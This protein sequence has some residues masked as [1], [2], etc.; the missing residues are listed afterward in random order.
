MKNKYEINYKLIFTVTALISLPFLL[1][2]ILLREGILFGVIITVVL[3]GFGV[4]QLFV[5]RIKSVTV[6]ST[7]IIIEYRKT[8]V[9]ISYTDINKIGHYKHGP[10]TERIFI[11]AKDYVYEIPF[12]MKDFHNMCGSIYS[13]LSKINMEH[14]ADEWFREK[15]GKEASLKG[16]QQ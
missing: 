8:S 12:D 7:A 5:Q 11:Y 16:V 3:N 6:D 4:S 15:F 10:L 13:G 14:A 1:L 9:K 2:T